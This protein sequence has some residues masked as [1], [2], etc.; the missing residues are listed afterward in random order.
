M[1]DGSPLD[2]LSL[3]EWFD[4]CAR[5][6]CAVYRSGRIARLNAAAKKF[7]RPARGL[8]IRDGRLSSNDVEGRAR[9]QRLLR[10]QT[11]ATYLLCVDCRN[12]PVLA[13]VL[14]LPSGTLIVTLHAANSVKLSPLNDLAD[15]LKLTTQQKRVARE[16]IAGKSVDQIARKMGVSQ[17]TIRTHLK[18]VFHKAGVHSQAGLISAYARC[19]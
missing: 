8:V 16:L 6:I 12:R 9:L 1:N 5:P 7:L 14:P 3:A 13:E 11:A 19:L 18:S 10:S 4:N 2:Q 15:A 17:Q